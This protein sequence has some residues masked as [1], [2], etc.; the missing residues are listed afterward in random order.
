MYGSIEVIV[1]NIPRP[2]ISKGALTGPHHNLSIVKSNDIA[3]ILDPDKT[4]DDPNWILC[5]CTKKSDNLH[6]LT[7]ARP[8][9]LWSHRA[10]RR[11]I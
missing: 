10:K 11:A 1:G 8:C 2:F 6:H 3:W 9:Q 5:N 4:P 7:L